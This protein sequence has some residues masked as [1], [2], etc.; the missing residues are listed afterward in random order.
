MIAETPSADRHR[1]DTYSRGPATS[2]LRAAV[3]RDD[4]RKKKIKRGKNKKTLEIS[5]RFAGSTRATIS[6]DRSREAV[7]RRVAKLPRAPGATKMVVDGY[8]AP[9]TLRRPADLGNRPSTSI[10][11]ALRWPEMR[12][13]R[14]AVYT[15]GLTPC[16]GVFFGLRGASQIPNS[17][18]ACA[19]AGLGAR[20]LV[21]N[22]AEPRRW[23]RAISRPDAA[24]RRVRPACANHP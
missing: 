5:A 12:H 3:C 15:T 13:Q 4:E 23:P 10:S 14:A 9:V 7:T 22:D 6:T 18:L 16:S 20:G 1:R 8:D 11:M 17:G 24:G 21:L 19:A 2:R